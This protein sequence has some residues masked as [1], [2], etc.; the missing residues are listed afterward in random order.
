M[1]FN[2]GV[3]MVSFK[4]YILNE[5]HGHNY[6]KME[7]PDQ[8]RAA[9]VEEHKAVMQYD[10]IAKVCKNQ[11]MKEVLLDIAAEEK[12]HIQELSTLLREFD[13]E[14]YYAMDQAEEELAGM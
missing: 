5:S 9:I 3:N 13:Q 4:K 14:E 10:A 12:V 8:L 1:I 7:I 2:R 6:E 11:K